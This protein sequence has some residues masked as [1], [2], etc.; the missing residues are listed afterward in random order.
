MEFAGQME[1]VRVQPYLM[2]FAHLYPAV[3]LT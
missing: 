3:V 2:D 1:I